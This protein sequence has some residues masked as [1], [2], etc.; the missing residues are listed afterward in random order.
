MADTSIKAIET[1][2]AELRLANFDQ[3]GK[4]ASIAA[5]MLEALHK[6]LAEADAQIKALV[7][8]DS[9]G[10]PHHRS[11][12]SWLG[13]ANLEH[14]K[15]A[16]ARHAARLPD[17][18]WQGGDGWALIETAPGAVRSTAEAVRGVAGRHRCRIVGPLE[19]QLVAL[20]LGP[21]TDSPV[22]HWKF[23]GEMPR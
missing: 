21:T 11:E 18:R 5:D 23:I 2:C 20:W 15:E 14:V 22:T 1:V 6:Q 9:K 12:K 19:G 4:R 16:L 17:L 8:V 7:W 13:V 3:Y 10:E